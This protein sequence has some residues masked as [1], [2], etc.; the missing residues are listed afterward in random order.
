MMMDTSFKST[1]GQLF[2]PFGEPRYGEWH[3]GQ[4]VLA[5]YYGVPKSCFPFLSF[6]I[7]HACMV[8]VAK[9]RHVWF[10]SSNSVGTNYFLPH[11][12]LLSIAKSLAIA[13][14]RGSMLEVVNM[15]KQGSH[16]WGMSV[17][18]PKMHIFRQKQAFHQQFHGQLPF[19][20]WLTS[21]WRNPSILSIIFP[22]R[23]FQFFFPGI[24]HVFCMFTSLPHRSLE[25]TGFQH[26]ALA[27]WPNGTDPGIRLQAKSAVP[28][29]SDC[30]RHGCC[31]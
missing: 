19:S 23:K 2:Y 28:T 3:N 24:P 21:M 8:S 12:F 29:A 20:S 16:H 26:W 11:I 9:L 15:G 10:E 4:N 14:L 17:V 31:Q 27:Q 5:W 13:G 6:K 22:T 30:K 7:D 25:I 1:P 18:P